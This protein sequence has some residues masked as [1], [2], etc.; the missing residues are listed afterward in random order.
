MEAAGRME[1]SPLSAFGASIEANGENNISF[2]GKGT[3]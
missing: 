1:T 2:F 3:L